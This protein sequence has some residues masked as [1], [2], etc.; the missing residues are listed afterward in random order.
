MPSAQDVL[1]ELASLDE[2]RT[3]QGITPLEYLRW[4]D[5][6][7][8]LRTEFPEEPSLPMGDAETFIRIE[9]RS[10]RSLKS[11]TMRNVRPTGIY[12]NTPFAPEIGTQF[13]LVVFVKDSRAEYRSRVEVVSNN[14]SSGFSTANLGMGM[15][16][17]D[18]ECELRAVLDRL[19]DGD[20]RSS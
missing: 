4:L 1:R 13:G 20:A 16:F 15:K 12:V 9:F 14:M 5:L 17:L 7:A 8:Q 2:R 3:T 19:C 11:A 10:E 18:P 6:E